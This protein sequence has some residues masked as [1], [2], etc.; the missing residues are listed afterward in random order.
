MRVLFINFRII[1][2]MLALTR[3]CQTEDMNEVWFSFVRVGIII[4]V[5]GVGLVTGIDALNDIGPHTRIVIIVRQL[6]Q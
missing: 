2:C 3:S 4:H 6:G 1:A 5:Y